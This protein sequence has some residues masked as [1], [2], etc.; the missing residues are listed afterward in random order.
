ML[1]GWLVSAARRCDAPLEASAAESAEVSAFAVLILTGLV[2]ADFTGA[3]AGVA[4][5]VAG[6]ASGVFIAAC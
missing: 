3:G 2:E 1:A 5:A 6:V 4:S